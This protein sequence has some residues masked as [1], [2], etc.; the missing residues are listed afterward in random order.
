MRRGRAKAGF[1]LVAAA[2]ALTIL[3]SEPAQAQDVGR[4]DEAETAAPGAPTADDDEIVV[5]A[6]LRGENLQD[7]PIAITAATG[8]QLERQNLRTITDLKQIASGFEV[9]QSANN[10]P[11][12]TLRGLGTSTATMAFEPSIGAFAD[13]IYLGHGRLFNASLFDVERVEVIRGTQAALL[14]KNT[15]LGAI[16]VATRG[17]GP[18]FGLDLT[19]SYDFE[20]GSYLLAG[21]I[22]V[23]L[24]DEL[25][26]RIAGQH[27]ARRGWV[28]YLFSD[29]YG[30]R[31]DTDAIRATGEWRPSERLTVRLSYQYSESDRRGDAV[32]TVN[33]WSQIAGGFPPFNVPGALSPIRNNRFPGNTQFDFRVNNRPSR[34]RS[35]TNLAVG[36]ISYALPSGHEITSLT[37]Y[38]R[39]NLSTPEP[40]GFG[41]FHFDLANYLIDEQEEQFSQELRLSSPQGR[42][43]EYLLGV[44]YLDDTWSQTL[45]ISG[46]GSFPGGPYNAANLPPIPTAAQPYFTLTPSARSVETLNSHTRDLSVFGLVTLNMTDA[47]AVDLGARYTDERRRGRFGRNYLFGAPFAAS[48]IPGCVGGVGVL[49]GSLPSCATAAGGFTGLR[50]QTVKSDPLDLSAGVRYRIGRNI[51]LFATYSEGTKGPG[52]VHQVAAVGQPYGPEEAVSMELGARTQ[53]D[54][55]F[56]SDGRLRL[57]VTGFRTTVDGLQQ[58]ILLA[59]R[60]V[61]AQRNVISTG[62]DSELAWQSGNFSAGAN[63]TYARARYREGADPT[64]ATGAPLPGAPRWS[65]SA[66]ATLMVP[67]DDGRALEL[68]PSVNFRSSMLLRD[69]TRGPLNCAPA[70]TIFAESCFFPRSGAYAKLN[71]RAAVGD[72]ADG[73]SLA[74]I[75]R[76]LNNVR[77]LAF[78]Y[79]SFGGYGTQATSDQP[80]TVVLQLTY[81]H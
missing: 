76:N 8:E 39:Y 5:T 73:W 15:S 18:D 35:D 77:R 49:A 60:F 19:A 53:F 79:P 16:S 69:W 33:D 38:L 43:F 24:S 31:I 74:V 59:G 64:V 80:R 47:L 21:G 36:R 54:G 67:I 13:G 42:L 65:G 44:F 28:N 2:S 17:P 4:P 22:D 3:R 26:I 27:D 32:E 1:T 45:D 61:L 46:Y 25:G 57:N 11:A 55:L 41:F 72:E 29:F 50:E 66:F 71:F 40:F 52:F 48:P 23:P 68:S 6:R 20:L 51:N 81:R 30:P 70:P 9:R 78:A 14:G 10:T 34:E 56:G 62:F 37:G 58:S 7:V 75:G 12:L 63:A